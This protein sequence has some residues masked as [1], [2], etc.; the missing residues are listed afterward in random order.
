MLCKQGWRRGAGRGTEGRARCDGSEA[1][2]LE[3]VVGPCGSS[4][5]SVLMLS[6]KEKTQ[7]IQ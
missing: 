1:G 6:V 4:P 2:Q 3:G 7:V 5:L